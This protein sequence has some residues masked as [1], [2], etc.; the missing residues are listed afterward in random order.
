MRAPSPALRLLRGLMAVAM[1]LGLWANTANA[2]PS[3]AMLPDW[4]AVGLCHADGGSDAPGPD[5]ALPHQHCAWCQSVVAVV[6][7]PLPAAVAQ[8]A[9]VDVAV[10]PTAALSGMAQRRLFLHAPRGPPAVV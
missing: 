4:L 6:L 3:H 5:K 8:P 1:L 2:A 10:P 9:L 7:P